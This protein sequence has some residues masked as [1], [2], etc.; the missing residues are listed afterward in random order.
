MGDGTYLFV[1]LKRQRADGPVLAV[2]LGYS[3][4]AKSCGVAW[5]GGGEP[6]NVQFGDAISLVSQLLQREPPPVLVLEAVLS[7]LHSPEGNPSIRGA[8]EKGRGWYWGPGAVSALAAR[9]FLEELGCRL[10]RPVLLGEAFLSN[11]S[12]PTRHCDDANKIVHDCWLAEPVP[13]IP[14]VEPLLPII[15]GVP[16]V[17][18]FTV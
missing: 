8:F 4:A 14:G 7:T 5:S 11:K 10:E 15:N 3:A 9:R 12:G 17:R 6:Q 18:V 16:S 1:A 2:D 13:L